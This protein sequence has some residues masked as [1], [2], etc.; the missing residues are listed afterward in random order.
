MAGSADG[1]R[2]TCPLVD[3]P[4]RA[5]ESQGAR[6]SRRAV[7]LRRVADTLE[8]IPDSSVMDLVLRD[9]ITEDCSWYSLTVYYALLADD[10]PGA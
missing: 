4:L 5:G 2:S 3:A 1:S 6:S 7:V 9:E 8:G 10:E